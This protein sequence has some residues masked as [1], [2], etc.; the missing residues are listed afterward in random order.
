MSVKRR[1]FFAALV[2]PPTAAPAAITTR[3]GSRGE[4]VGL[5]GFGA[6]RYPTI[7]GSHANT[8]R[9]GSNAPIALPQVQRQIDYCI[10]HGVNYFDTSPVYCR[11]E[12]E[13]VLGDCLAKHPRDKWLVATKLSNFNAKFHPFEAA[14]GMYEESFRL[15][16]TDH[17]DF[18]LLHSIGGGGKDAMKLFNARFIDNGMLD[19]LMKEREAGR[20]RNLGF[21]FHGSEAVFRHA[22]EMHEK[23]H[24]DFVQIQLN[25]VDWHHAKEVNPRNV[26]A[27]TLYNLCAER[28]IPV[29]VMEPLLGG[30]LAKF[31]YNVQRKLTPIDAAATPANWSFR[32]AGSLPGVLTVLSGMTYLEHIEENVKTYSPLKPLDD[33]EK[34]AL[35][36]AA[37]AFL[38]DDSI[39]CTG[40][41]YCM[42]CPYGLDIPGLFACWNTALTEDRMPDDPSDP[43]YAERRRRFLID[44]ERA[45]P[46]LRRAER[47]TGCGRCAPHCPQ[48]IDIPAMIRKVDAFVEKLRRNGRA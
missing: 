27:E 26:N 46:K 39:P 33:R 2:N 11:G 24:W 37:R 8:N 43:D 35:E 32:F 7:D 40:C 14:K 28:N 44:Y 16:R 45:I 34:L 36:R 19:F 47:C 41:D 15:L 42:P 38:S 10:E 1:A 22:L 17:I 18:Y 20:I 31:N 30:R 25:F 21:S 6:M 4:R 9:G 5:L 3:L 12:S 23:V 29:V 48:S 13:K